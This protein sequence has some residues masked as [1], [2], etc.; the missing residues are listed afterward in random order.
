MTIC[1]TLGAYE[2]SVWNTPAQTVPPVTPV[3]ASTGHSRCPFHQH[4]YI[5][6]LL[7]KQEKDPV[8]I[9]ECPDG[10]FRKN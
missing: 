10:C 7:L 1:F 9:D 2:A 5:P 4:L 3:D 6:K 8:R